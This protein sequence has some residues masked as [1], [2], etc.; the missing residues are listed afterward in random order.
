[1]SHSSYLLFV[2]VATLFM[3]FIM[4]TGTTNAARAAWK[5][6]GTLLSL[7]NNKNPTPGRYQ[8]PVMYAAMEDQ[9]GVE[10]IE[11]PEPS[12]MLLIKSP[13]PRASF[14]VRRRADMSEMGSRIAQLRNFLM[15][16]H[17]NQQKQRARKYYKRIRGGLKSKRATAK[18]QSD[19]GWYIT[20]PT[21]FATCRIGRPV[22]GRCV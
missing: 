22:A 7:Q 6:R 20:P 18:A 17:N 8:P 10:L 13:N 3:A 19:L 9:P 12:T 1:M 11:A 14:M 4:S 16:D 2:I 15:N 5:H 21:D